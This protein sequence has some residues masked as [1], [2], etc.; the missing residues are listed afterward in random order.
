MSH[1]GL[2]DEKLLE[3][4]DVRDARKCPND[5][6][7][8]VLGSCDQYVCSDCGFTVSYE[9]MQMDEIELPTRREYIP[10]VMELLILRQAKRI[11]ENFK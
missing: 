9:R 6:A 3:L 8:L 1:C 2:S 4:A 11:R 5:E 10:I 7:E